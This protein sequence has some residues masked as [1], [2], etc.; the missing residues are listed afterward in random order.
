MIESLQSQTKK[1]CSTDSEIARKWFST[2]HLKNNLKAQSV[3][4]GLHTIS[5]QAVS[6]IL[7]IGSNLVLARML[8]PENFGLIAMVTAV[9]GFVTLFADMGLSTSIIQK[10]Q[11]NQKQVSVIFWINAA[12]SLGL[13]IILFFLA[14]LLVS[15]YHEP[16]LYNITIVM[17]AGIFIAGLSLQHSALMKRQMRFRTISFIQ[18]GST[19]A[20]LATGII[21]AWQGFG[22]WALVAINILTPVFTSISLWFL[23]DWRPHFIFSHNIKS[24]LRF[25]MG[26]SGFELVNYF[27]RNMD[28]V[29]IGK[30]SGAFIL[31]L[32][33]KAYQLLMLPIVQLRNP[34]NAVALPALSALQSDRGKFAAY[35]RRYLFTLAFFSM[36]VVMFLGVFSDEII[37]VVLGKQ[38]IEAS[39]LF[40]LLVVTAFI[41]PVASSTGLVLISTGRIR[42][43]FRIG[44]VSSIVIVLGFFIGVQWG[45]PGVAISF[46]TTSYLLLLPTLIYCFRDTDIN[47]KK[48]FNEVQYPLLFSLLMGGGLMIL[49]NNLPVHSNL[50]MVL[51]GFVAGAVFY[52]VPWQLGGESRH[53]FRQLLSLLLE[54]AWFRKKKQ[55]SQVP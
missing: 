30:F 2:V 40:K 47:L 24:F 26:M 5:G 23:C 53:K 42:R 38:W 39:F 28:N 48:F 17:A 55:G 46:A 6:F 51:A 22:Y 33:S 50:L 21:L 29:L 18:M 13:A 4:G 1:Y 52:L 19:A 20:S 44:L 10:D 36:P 15:F 14:P 12:I 11:I 9:S 43:Y 34:L 41:Q 27:A 32:Y 7:S 35:Y 37:L 45:A 8:A 49:K 54:H 31:G 25:G 3:K 16:R